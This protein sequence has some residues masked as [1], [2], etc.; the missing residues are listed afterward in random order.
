MPLLKTV[1]SV[2]VA[3]PGAGSDAAFMAEVFGPAAAAL[4][5]PLIPVDPD[6]RAVRA[7]YEQALDAAVQDAGPVIVC[8]FSIGS[9]IGAQWASEHQDQCAGVL[10]CLPAWLGDPAGAA[11]AEN[12][13]HTAKLL[14][15]QGLGPILADMRAGSPG[16]VAERLARSWT[17]QWPGLPDAFEEIGKTALPTEAA[18][19]AL[20]IPV[21]LGA[22]RGDPIHPVQAAR[23][24]LGAL[25]KGT[26]V[27]L[28]FAEVGADP[29]RL[30]HAVFDAFA[31]LAA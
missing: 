23:R 1:A 25:A 28:D 5:L 9:H 8:G 31:E 10:A 7:S 21:V 26:L 19:A 30:G 6:P 14:R 17:A 20:R 22:V 11:A 3:L 2:V 13:K 4:G 29:S 12:A 24:W 18:L 15:E 16:W 27:E